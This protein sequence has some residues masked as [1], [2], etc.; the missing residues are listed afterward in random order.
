MPDSEDPEEWAHQGVGAIGLAMKVEMNTQ[1]TGPATDQPRPTAL[2]IMGPALRLTNGHVRPDQPPYISM[3]LLNG[4]LYSLASGAEFIAKPNEIDLREAIADYAKVGKVTPDQMA[5][6]LRLS[7]PQAQPD[8][9]TKQVAYVW[10]P[11]T[12]AQRL[13]NS[14]VFFLRVSGGSDNVDYLVGAD[15]VQAY[16]PVAVNGRIAMGPPKAQ[17]L[18]RATGPNGQILPVVFRGRLGIQGDEEI[19]GTESGPEGVAVFG[20]RNAPSPTLYG[21]EIPFEVNLQ[22]DRLDAGVSAGREDAT[23]VGVVVRDLTSGKSTSQTI[24]L[25]SNL[26]TFFTVPADAITGPDFDVIISCQSPGEEIGLFPQRSLSLVASRESFEVNLIK[27]LAILWMM[28]ILVLTLAIFCSTF[29]S[30]PIAIMLTVVLLLGRWGF[31]QM[32]DVTRPGLGRQI[33]NDFKFNDAPVA[34]VV[35][36]GVDALSSAMAT[37][38]SSSPTQGASTPSP[39]SKAASRFL[40]RNCLRR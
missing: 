10:I 30:W 7:E 6:A 2:G 39:I 17:A 32:A 34:K 19:R 15:P 38:P 21:G 22:V 37:C 35:S 40:R 14:D 12:I 18:P 13:F 27:S 1:R 25:E 9:S 24:Q 36:T 4:D 20:F 8:G 31:D 26:V 29:L 5:N 11:P 33:V 16:V 3:E 28:S 23:T